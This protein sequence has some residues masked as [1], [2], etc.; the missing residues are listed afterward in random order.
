MLVVDPDGL[1]ELAT[2]PESTKFLADVVGEAVAAE[3]ARNVRDSD[4]AKTHKVLRTNPDGTVAVGSTHSFAHLDE[5]GSVNNPATHALRRAAIT[6][7]LRL[8]E[9][10]K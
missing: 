6:A 4:V 7:G 2:N 3:T 10:G 1:D 9:D 8:E 5:W